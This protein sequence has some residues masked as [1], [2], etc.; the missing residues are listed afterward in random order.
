MAITFSCER[1]QK[2]LSVKAEYAGRRAKCPCGAV[3]RVPAAGVLA[4]AAAAPARP[5]PRAPAA[6]P[7]PAPARDLSPAEAEAIVREVAEKHRANGV[8]K[9]LGNFNPRVVARAR[10]NFAADMTDDEVPLAQ[11][12]RS[13]LQNGS[14][15]L[16][17]TNRRLYS[18]A[19][20]R[21]VPLRDVLVATFERPTQLQVFV[22]QMFWGLYRLLGKWPQPQLLVNGNPVDTGELLFGFW[23]DVLAR[24]GRESRRGRGS[25]SGGRDRD[26]VLAAA[27]AAGRGEDE[28]VAGLTQAGLDGAAVRPT[29]ADMIALRDAPRPAPAVALIGVGLAVVLLGLV[30]TAAG[31][32]GD[33]SLIFI[34]PVIVGLGV[35]GA[36]VYRLF[37]RPPWTAE[38]LLQAWRTRD[39]S[40]RGR[41]NG[42]EGY[43]EGET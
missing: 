32:S 5:A 35:G 38:Q 6:R 31:S 19:L 33:E 42:A 23:T 20:G 30:L 26:R 2:K 27:V 8:L 18:S 40:A 39:R 34:G 15:G 43:A 25:P 3:V 14:A 17:L 9:K 4:P 22:A 37:T 1:C 13:F 12:D 21:P 16:L 10:D 11:V 28:V 29:V 24:L 36:G 7:A 41:T